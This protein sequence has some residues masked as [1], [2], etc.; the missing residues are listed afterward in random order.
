VSVNEYKITVGSMEFTNADIAVGSLKFVTAIDLPGAECSADEMTVDVTWEAGE[1][2]LFSPKDYD[3]VLTQDDYWFATADVVTGDITEENYGTPVVV[4]IGDTVYARFFLKNVQ[5]VARNTYRIIATSAIGLLENQDHPGGVYTGETVQTVFSSIINGAFSY[6]LSLDVAGQRVVGWLPYDTARANLHRVM[7]ALGISAKKDSGGDVYFTFVNRESPVDVSDSNV[8][9]G[10]SVDYVSPATAADVTEH[11]Y[12]MLPADVEDDLFYNVGQVPAS[13]MLIK[14][15]E[16]HY[17]LTASG[18][19]TI[20][21][22]G[23]NYAVVSGIGTLKGKKYTHTTQ[24]VRQSIVT[25]AQENVITSESDGL[26]NPLNSLNVA[27]R[28]LAYYGGKKTIRA[29]IVLNG[30]KSGDAVNITDAYGDAYTGIIAKMEIVASSFLRAA[31]QIVTDYIPTGQGNYFTTMYRFTASGTWTVPAGVTHVRIVVIGGGTGGGGGHN[32]QAGRGGDKRYGGWQTYT[33]EYYQATAIRKTYGYASGDG[34]EAGHGGSGG[35]GGTGGAFAVI[36]LDVTPGETFAVTV[37]YGGSGGARSAY[38][39]DDT[40][41]A[42]GTDTSVSSSHGTITSA[43]GYRVTEGY[44]D[45]I[46]NEVYAAAGV[47][48][49]SGGDGG[50]T[51]VTSNNGFDGNDLAGVSG[52]PGTGTGT[53][54]SGSGGAGLYYNDPN[55]LIVHTGGGGGGGAAHGA[56]G[57]AG[58]SATHSGSTYQGGTGG[59]G[60]NAAAP[61]AAGYGCG[62]NGGHGGGGGGNAGGA[63]IRGSV[64]GMYVSAGVGGT[65]GTGSAGGAGGNGAALFY[66]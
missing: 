41:G 7:F 39:A 56:A 17:D 22:S 33:A 52:K 54:A 66:Y 53:Y 48:G 45:P 47:A 21:S 35:A 31:C 25:T 43:G 42:S 65:G 62:G 4:Y 64:D 14:F 44:Y 34:D 20:D 30:E 19:L 13:S 10:G 61:T 26:I 11:Q 5:R 9:L 12:Y 8:F 49:I 15:S 59:I 18:G 29:D 40:P 46:N 2:L 60:A 28:L 50:T 16:P 37:G 58:G 36:D 63:D 3:G 55:T 38:G 6:S 57:G 24:V 51:T 1:V 32:G 23:A 27:K